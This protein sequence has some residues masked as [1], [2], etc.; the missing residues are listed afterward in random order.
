MNSQTLPEARLAELPGIARKALESWY[1]SGR[2]RLPA[3]IT[4]SLP[5]RGAFVTLL[6]ARGQLRGCIGHILPTRAHLEEEVAECAVL[7][8][9]QDP[10]FPPVTEAE[11]GALT[12]EVSVL[13]PPEAI[14]GPD[15]LDP[16]RYG[17]IVR[18]GSRQGVLLP[19]LDGV[20]TVDQQLA[21]VRQKAGI[22]PWE[23]VEL[24]RFTATKIRENTREGRT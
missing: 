20:N 7:A 9:T 18:S 23:P 14:P 16:A 6:D 8:A 21:I 11:L 17:V 5:P 24:F 19:A 4:P 2:I 12:I 1:A 15:M 22:A 3:G 13:S 10:R